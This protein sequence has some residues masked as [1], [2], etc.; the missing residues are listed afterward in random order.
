MFMVI[1][2]GVLTMSHVDFIFRPFL[3]F[4]T[5]HI[6]FTL[7]GDNL[8]DEALLALE[9]IAHL[10]RFVRRAAILEHRQSGCHPCTVF[11]PTGVDRTAVHIHGDDFGCQFYLL[12][13]HFTLSIKMGKATFGKHYG[14][15]RFVDD[16]CIQRFLLSPYRVERNGVRA[17]GVHPDSIVDTPTTVPCA[18]GI[19][20]HA[21]HQTGRQHQK[22]DDSM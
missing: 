16:R 14:V 19:R 21:E 3:G 6:A 20:V 22:R 15:I 10:L 4:L 5:H 18:L 11:H 12:I 2:S 17:Q 1:T 9:V 7:L 8:V 13:I